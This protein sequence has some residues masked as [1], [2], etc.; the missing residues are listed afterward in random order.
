MPEAAGAGDRAIRG[1]MRR[2]TQPSD[3]AVTTRLLGDLPRRE[4]P[5]DPPLRL[6]AAG[7]ELGYQRG[8]ID[9]VREMVREGDLQMGSSEEARL[10]DEVARATAELVAR[11]E[12]HYGAFSEAPEGPWREEGLRE[13]FLIDIAPDRQDDARWVIQNAHQ[14]SDAP[15]PVELVGRMALRSVGEDVR[16]V[17]RFLTELA[18]DVAE[19]DLRELVVELA[20]GCDELATAISNTLPEKP[21]DQPS[22]V[23]AGVESAR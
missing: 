12:Q 16:E 10:V 6:A 5:L 18:A 11:I 9:R 7:R 14:A 13:T 1:S 17:E 8:F 19:A 21:V 22:L 2:E 20:T 15:E 4:E 3:L 23:A